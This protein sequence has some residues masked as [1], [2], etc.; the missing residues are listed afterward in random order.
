MWDVLLDEA[1]RYA[2][3][4]IVGG[5][6]GVVIMFVRRSWSLLQ[7]IE[8]EFRPNGGGSMRDQVV[9]IKQLVF[10]MTARQC[11]LVDGLGDPMWESDANG[12]CVKANRA[13]LQLTGRSLQ[14]MQGG[15]WENSIVSADRDRVWDEWCDAVERRRSFESRYRIRSIDGEIYT[16]DAIATPIRDGDAVSGWLGKYRDVAPV[17]ARKSIARE[18]RRS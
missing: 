9:Q 1:W 14:E 6:G 17:K 10:N 16:V 12:D 5:V 3:T 13:L 2:V 4:I 8:A 18:S 15:G 7:A 11:A